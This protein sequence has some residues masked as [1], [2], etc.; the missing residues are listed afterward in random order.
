VRAALLGLGVADEQEV[1]PRLRRPYRR[2]A[3]RAELA[4]G[5][6]LQIVRDDDAAIADL[7][8]EIVVH[9]EPR[10]GG[11]HARRGI[12]AR[13]ERVRGHDAVHARRHC[14]HE[15]WQVVSVHVGP[16]RVD[17]GQAEM[18]V[19]GR[20]ALAGEVLGARRQPLRLHAPHARG[21]QA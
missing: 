2:L 3:D 1:V 7:A 19:D 8:A 10:E 21:A 5:A 6:H 20:V 11:G 16:V 18:R 15:G 12:E 13:V 4:D 17:D 14:L 9:D